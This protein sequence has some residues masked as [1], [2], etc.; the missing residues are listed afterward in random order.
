MAIPEGNTLAMDPALSEK[1]KGPVVPLPGPSQGGSGTDPVG[2]AVPAPVPNE[3]S[4]AEVT[5]PP[6]QVGCDDSVA[7]DFP[8]EARDAG[9]EGKVF[10]ELLIDERGKIAEAKVVKGLGFGLDEL[11][12]ARVKTCSFSPAMKGEQAVSFRIKRFPVLLL[13]E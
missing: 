9:V 1:P 5:A 12:L 11:A 7:K 8:K 4:A 2:P 10:L 13:P 3:V 6:K